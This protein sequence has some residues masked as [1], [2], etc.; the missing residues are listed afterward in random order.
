MKILFL[1]IEAHFISFQ[2]KVEALQK[3]EVNSVEMINDPNSKGSRT[4]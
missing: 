2:F 1:R 3:D 4:T